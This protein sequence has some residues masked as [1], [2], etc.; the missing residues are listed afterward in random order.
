LKQR[1]RG[2]YNAGALRMVI[3]DSDIGE[4]GDGAFTDWTAKLK[5][6][7]GNER[8]AAIAMVSIRYNVAVMGW[9]AAIQSRYLS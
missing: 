5:G 1:G 2:Y 7:F 6:H 8:G 4:I 9:R 3:D